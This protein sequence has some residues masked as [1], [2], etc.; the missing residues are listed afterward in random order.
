VCTRRTAFLNAVR[1]LVKLKAAVTSRLEAQ[2]LP[3][4]VL[5]FCMQRYLTRIGR[6][7]YLS[8]VSRAVHAGSWEVTVAFNVISESTV[9][10]I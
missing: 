5:L 9:F 8:A 7:F 2:D 10:E 6:N 4:L 1:S 3:K